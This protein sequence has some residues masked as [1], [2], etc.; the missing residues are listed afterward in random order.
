M[1]SEHECKCQ[2]GCL[3][4]VM[5]VMVIMACAAYLADRDD[6]TPAPPPTAEA[7]P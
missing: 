3:F 4:T 5:A 7:T 2:S 1:A 6:D